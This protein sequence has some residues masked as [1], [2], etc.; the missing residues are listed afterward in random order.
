[1]TNDPVMLRMPY[2]RE[3]ICGAV[4]L[5][6]KD[7]KRKEMRQAEV[8]ACGDVCGVPTYKLC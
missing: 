3:G 1:V 8:M 5:R 2:I 4:L 7:G 6:C